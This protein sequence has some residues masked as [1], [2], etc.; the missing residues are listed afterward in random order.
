MYDDSNFVPTV[1]EIVI[2]HMVFAVMFF[3]YAARNWENADQR[4]ELNHSSN[5]HYHYALGFFAQ[6]VANLNLQKVQA[7]AIICLHLRSFPKPGAC[8]KMTAITLNLAI[9]LGLHRSAREWVSP[10]SVTG[11]LEAEMRKRVFWSI[12]T[13]HISVSGKLGRPMAL[14]SDDFDVEIPDAIDDELI[15]E[16]GLD[17]SRP[18]KCAFL[19]SIEEFKSMTILMD[20]Y[21]IIYAVKRTSPEVY[22]NTVRQL[23]HRMQQWYDQSPPQLRP[24][25]ADEENRVHAQYMITWLLEFQLLLHHPSLSLTDSPEFNHEN[26]TICMDVSRKLLYH[27]KIIQKYRSLDTNWQSGALYVLA[28]STTLFGHWERKDEITA[29][30]LVVLRDEMDSWLSI[31]GDVGALL[32]PL[33]LSTASALLADLLAGSGKRLQ[34]TVQV[35]VEGTLKRLARHLASMNGPST[36]PHGGHTSLPDA[37]FPPRQAPNHE[38]YHSNQWVDSQ[39]LGG[40]SKLGAA[41]PAEHPY[42]SSTPSSYQEPSTSRMT[43]FHQ[44]IPPDPTAYPASANNHHGYATQTPYPPVGSESHEMP[45]TTATDFLFSGSAPVPN[46]A[47]SSYQPAPAM[48]LSSPSNVAASGPSSWQY[49]TTNL[50]SNAEPEEY[51]SSANALMQLGGHGDQSGNAG[52]GLSTVSDTMMGNSTATD[53]ASAQPRWPLIIFGN[54]QDTTGTLT[55]HAT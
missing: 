34:Q 41:D 55:P 27:V 28:I 22:V 43:S 31:M 10:S 52:V 14:R 37:S 25:S 5:L 17:T 21:N 42:S 47:G 50:A 18:S 32:G 33:G 49:W 45:R 2:V 9:D 3:Q 26:L 39:A 38:G 23:N 36:V 4:S 1:A 54:E 35:I 53:M 29:A 46:L 16:G 6:L 13:I 24:E 19:V 48:Y 30:S 11:P 7:L 8:W 40:P 12:L 51:M 15:D 44:K 20:L